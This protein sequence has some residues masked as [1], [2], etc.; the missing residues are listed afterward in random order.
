MMVKTQMS[1]SVDERD[2]A[3]KAVEADLVQAESKNALSLAATAGAPISMHGH[4]CW[5]GKGKVL[6]HNST[7]FCGDG[8]R[9][10]RRG[11]SLRRGESAEVPAGCKGSKLRKLEPDMAPFLSNLQES[12]T[13]SQS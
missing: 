11:A 7:P 10:G 6:P 4:A 9:L 2:Q 12:T 13:N 1:P 3:S 5:T 8:P